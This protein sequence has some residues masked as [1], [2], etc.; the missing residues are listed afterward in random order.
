MRMVEVGEETLPIE[1]VEAKLQ[2]FIYRRRME[3]CEVEIIKPIYYEGLNHIRC[4]LS[5]NGFRRRGGESDRKKVRSH[6]QSIESG[7]RALARRPPGNL[8]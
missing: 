4:I 5:I 7:E 2:G 3:G 1:I 8:V 6:N